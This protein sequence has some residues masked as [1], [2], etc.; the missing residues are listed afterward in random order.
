VP[1]CGQ[2]DRSFCLWLCRIRAYPSNPWSKFSGVGASLDDVR[3][4]KGAHEA[5]PYVLIVRF[6]QK[7]QAILTRN[8]AKIPPAPTARQHP[9][10]GQRPRKS[11]P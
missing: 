5:R 3:G 6:D 4:G 8:W 11:F 9:S 1:F 2:S 7:I 10:L